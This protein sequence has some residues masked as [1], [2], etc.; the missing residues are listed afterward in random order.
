MGNKKKGQPVGS[1]AG[2]PRAAIS[3]R[4]G[5]S[6]GDSQSANHDLLEELGSAEA[7]LRDLLAR[8]NG[9]GAWGRGPHTRSLLR[10][11]ANAVYDYLEAETEL[12]KSEAAK[13]KEAE[14]W[15]DDDAF[16]VSRDTRG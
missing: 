12:A 7:D 4:A 6:Y 14:Q 2:R 1:A 13:R 5:G 16:P 10:D 3:N 15:L 8:A 9:D 11:L